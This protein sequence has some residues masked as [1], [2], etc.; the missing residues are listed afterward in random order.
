MPRKSA[1]ALSVVSS[2]DERRARVRAPGHLPAQVRTIFDEITASVSTVH[3]RQCD[4]PLIEALAVAIHTNRQ[5]TAAIEREGLIVDGRVNAHVGIVDR[6][7]KL[8][9]SL[10]VKLRLTPTGRLDRKVAGQTTRDKA[11][12]SRLDDDAVIDALLDAEEDD[13]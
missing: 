8:I 7:A 13:E 10:S 9:A 6:T 12:P 2:M 3:L 5:A 4:S 11:L 1:A